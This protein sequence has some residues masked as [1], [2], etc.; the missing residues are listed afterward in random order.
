M[1]CIGPSV[2]NLG[3]T[4]AWL[5]LSGERVKPARLN[6]ANVALTSEKLLVAHLLASTV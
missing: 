4:G 2:G 1:V 6:S 3:Q 5:F